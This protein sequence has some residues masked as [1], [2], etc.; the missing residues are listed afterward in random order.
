MNSGNANQSFETVF[1]SLYP[2][3]ANDRLWQFF[4]S[5]YV[6]FDTGDL[7]NSPHYFITK[8]RNSVVLKK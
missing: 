6:T 8:A 4:L 3:K 2:S 7:N 1:N 5:T